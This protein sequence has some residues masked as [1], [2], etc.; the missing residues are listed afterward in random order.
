MRIKRLQEKT[1][2]KTGHAPD[3]QFIGAFSALLLFGLMILTSAGSA[4]GYQKFGDSYYFIKHQLLLGVLPGLALLLIFTKI[5]YQKLQ[6]ISP[7][8][9]LM[10]ILLLISVFIPGIGSKYG[11][12]QSWI[13]I[14]GFSFQPS[15]LVKLTFLLYLSAWLAKR[16]ESGVRDF[17]YGFLPFVFVIGIISVLM[18]MQPDMGTLSI[19]IFMCMAIFFASGAK[20]KHVSGLIIVGISSILL[21]IKASPYRA[22][23]LT[24]FLHPELDPLGIGYHINQAFLA[25]GSGKFWGR[26]FGY[27]RQKF[28]YLPEVTGDSIFAVIAEELGFLFAFFTILLFLYLMFRGYKIAQKA[29]DSF[30]MLVA[31]G[32]ISWFIF[33]AFFNICSMVGL[34]PM[35]G[36]PLPFVSSGGTA[37]AVL[38]MA[39][40]ILINI[41]KQTTTK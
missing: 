35:T 12:A 8:L 30:G 11:G 15:E 24:T 33:Q 19:I 25:I 16:G 5:N 13:T 18:L 32:I 7:F 22:A 39:I 36:V 31:T 29:P 1:K 41:S 28:S 14:F 2:A 23:R 21:L 26:G 40:G 17:Y 6:K 27:S 37:I 9:L 20:I 38:M 4:I 10:S 34:M 3:W